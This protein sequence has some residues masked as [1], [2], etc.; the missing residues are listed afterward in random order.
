MPAVVPG[1]AINPDDPV[2]RSRVWGHAR[3]YERPPPSANA[4]PPPRR[5]PNNRRPCPLH[6]SSLPRP[7]IITDHPVDQRTASGTSRGLEP[8]WP[9]PDPSPLRARDPGRSSRALANHPRA[10]PSERSIRPKPGGIGRVESFRAFPSGAIAWAI[11]RLPLEGTRAGSSPNSTRNRS[12]WKAERQASFLSA[13]RSKATCL[14][15]LCLA[16]QRYESATRE[17]APGR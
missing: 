13:T 10:V 12:K 6:P 2:S 4:N 16:Q 9:V 8:P 11:A 3:P 17:S 7:A 14:P 15:F 1:S 5:R